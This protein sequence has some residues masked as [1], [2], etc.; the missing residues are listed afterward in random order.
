MAKM[1]KVDKHIHTIKYSSKE[2]YLEEDVSNPV[3]KATFY[4]QTKERRVFCRVHD[5][6]LEYLICSLSGMHYDDDTLV[7]QYFDLSRLDYLFNAEGNVTF[8]AI[9]K[10]HPEDSFDIQQ[11]KD[12]ALAK[13]L[14]KRDKVINQI[15]GM[16][17]EGV[18]KAFGN[19][20]NQLK[21]N[22]SSKK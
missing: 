17:N 13:C 1:M 11:G 4:I 14:D 19:I 9:A 22:A 21:Y 18:D 2:E 3:L 10:C 5:V 15:K 8:I 12:I 16:L 7:P 20:G 6:R